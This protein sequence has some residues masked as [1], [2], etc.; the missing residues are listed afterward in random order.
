MRHI[1]LLL[2]LASTP[3]FAEVFYYSNQY[4]TVELRSN[5]PSLLKFDKP[6]LSSSCQPGLLQF[7]SVDSGVL[8]LEEKE[9][10]QISEN[11][12]SEKD[13]TVKQL[14][15]VVPQTTSGVIT[16]SF[17]LIG[18]EEV[19]VRFSL[20]ENIARPFLDFKPFDTKF[21]STKVN[22]HLSLLGSLVKGDSLYL[23]DISKDYQS[24]DH[25]DKDTP[26]RC[27]NT[28]HTT[29][30]AR[31]ELSY[32]GTDAKTTA[33]SFIVT[34]EKNNSFTD[35]ADLKTSKGKSPFYSVLADQ[36]PSYLK[37]EKLT[38]HILTSHQMTK[39][40]ILELLP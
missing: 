31:Y 25:G 23:H 39:I 40:E 3:C 5:Q 24:C 4:L 16:C 33:W 17:T 7:E 27:R 6:P 29:E 14:I 11:H 35:L 26:Y 28:I 8:S 18:G 34:L 2:L 10:V 38:H 13:S 15:R 37:G 30:N 22:S 20:N 32:V 12:E 1:K 9:Q 21:T 19:P 36:K